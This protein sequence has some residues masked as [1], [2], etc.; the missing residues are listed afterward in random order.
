MRDLARRQ[1]SAG[2]FA[3][4]GRPASEGKGS[5]GTASVAPKPDPATLAKID[6]ELFP[7]LF[8]SGS[9]VVRRCGKFQRPLHHQHP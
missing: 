2:D 9:V 8:T 5:P 6:E 4:V 3:T 7:G 1:G